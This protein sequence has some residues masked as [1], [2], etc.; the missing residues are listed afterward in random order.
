VFIVCWTFGNFVV[1]IAESTN[2]C[3]ELV[4]NWRFGLYEYA[5]WRLSVRFFLCLL[6]FS[7]SGAAL[8]LLRC[9]KFNTQARGVCGQALVQRFPG[10]S[11]GQP[12]FM[13]RVL[14]KYNPSNLLAVDSWQWLTAPQGAHGP[15]ALVQRGWCIEECEFGCTTGESSGEAD[16]GESS[17]NAGVPCC[18]ENLSSREKSG[19]P[20]RAGSEILAVAM[21]SLKARMG[22]LSHF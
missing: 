16:C 20:E 4:F 18:D 1:G 7:H 14:A 3:I 22:M 9:G 17:G 13:H 5:C 2:R 11:G 19:P 15:S 12:L 10:S 6:E 21:H 8:S